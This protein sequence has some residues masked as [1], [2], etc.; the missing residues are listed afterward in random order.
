[1][2][3]N[4]VFAGVF[5]I[6]FKLK[7]EKSIDPLFEVNNYTVTSPHELVSL[8]MKIKDPI[9]AIKISKYM[10]NLFNYSSGYFEKINKKNLI[11]NI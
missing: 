8:I 2:C 6:Y 4:A 3:I 9:N 5:P 11:K 10:S 7:N 1:M